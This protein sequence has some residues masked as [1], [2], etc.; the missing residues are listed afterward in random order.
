MNSFDDWN[1]LKNKL[2]NL[3]MSINI[4][5]RSVYFINLGK[6]IGFEENGKGVLFLRPIIVLKKFNKYLFLGI[7]LTS[8]N[9]KNKN[10]IFYYQFFINNKN[11]CAILSQI[12][13]F[14]T[15]RILNKIG[16]VSINYFF[17]IKKRI[18]QMLD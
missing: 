13:L 12:R 10:N 7:P 16:V 6:N 4:K 18:K 5:E 11:N 17:E 14:D 9:L 2:N 15:K 8:S 3:K 1:I